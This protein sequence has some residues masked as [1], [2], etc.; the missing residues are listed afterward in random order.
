MVEAR[1]GRA[2]NVVPVISPSLSD[3]TALRTR[4]M[5]TALSYAAQCTLLISTKVIVNW[6]FYEN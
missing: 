3:S 6:I 1:A 5:D 2:R 4:G